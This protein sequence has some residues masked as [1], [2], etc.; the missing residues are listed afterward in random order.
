MKKLTGALTVF[1]ACVVFVTAFAGCMANPEKQIIGKWKDST[2]IVGYEFFEGGTVKFSVM[3]VPVDGSYS[4]D[5][6][7]ETITLTGTVLVK[8][9]TQTY[10]YAIE[11]NKLT[12]TD[13]S[14]GNAATYMREP[15]STTTK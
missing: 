10:K 11:E 6:K 13:L 8:S 4:M 3:G 2:G 12:L 1:L 15:G 9:V 5:K 7:E 14:S